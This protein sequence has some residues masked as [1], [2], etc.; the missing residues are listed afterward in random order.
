VAEQF[1]NGADVVTIRQQVRGE[2]VPHR[3]RP[4]TLG[5]AGLARSASDR[6]LYDGLVQVVVALIRFGGRF[7]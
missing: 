1:L 3:V 5:D 7:G 6:A 2:G 4:D